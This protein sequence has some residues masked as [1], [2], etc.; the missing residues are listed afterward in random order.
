MSV[1][2]YHIKLAFRLTERSRK[3]M[4]DI[5]RGSKLRQ[6]AIADSEA[7][8]R[9]KDS[10]HN[11]R[12]ASPSQI[13]DVTVIKKT[14]RKT[15]DMASASAATTPEIQRPLGTQKDAWTDTVIDSTHMTTSVASTSDLMSML[16]TIIGH[17]GMALKI[18][19]LN[20]KSMLDEQARTNSEFV[21][22]KICDLVTVAMAAEQILHEQVVK[23]SRAD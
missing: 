3:L 21:S 11:K 23:S 13:I 6:Q 19:N 5:S 4:E 12:M 15:V 7:A 8:K 18:N 16:R 10:G 20:R 1:D 2:F 14:T 22:S 17:G 9:A